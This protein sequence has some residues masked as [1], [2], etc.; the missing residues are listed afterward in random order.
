MKIK[1]IYNFLQAQ[2]IIGDE[3][4]EITTLSHINE[5]IDN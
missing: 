4:K 3:E 1:D 2:K 5:I